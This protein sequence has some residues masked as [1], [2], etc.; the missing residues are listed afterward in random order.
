MKFQ[1]FR[2]GSKFDLVINLR[3][4][5]ALGLEFRHRCLCAPTR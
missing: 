5:K 2:M 3:S 1:T 4:A